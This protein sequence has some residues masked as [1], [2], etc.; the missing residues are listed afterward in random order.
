MQL[1]IEAQGSQKNYLATTA[2]GGDYYQVWKE[3][4][5]PSWSIYCKKY[6]IGLIVFDQNIVDEDDSSYKSGAW[7]KLLIGS[8]LLKE[9]LEASNVCHLDTDI[10]I[11]P[12][13]P[14]IFCEYDSE[15]I[16]V[17]SQ[18]RNMPYD[19]MY[20][21]R[22]I[23]FYRHYFYDERYPLDSSLFIS[24]EGLWKYCGFAFHSDYFCSGVFVFN[25]RKHN[26]LLKS[27]FYDYGSD[28]LGG[29]E[30]VTLN[31]VV[32][33]Y[34]KIQWLDY[35][36]QALWVNEMASKY[37]FLYHYGRNDKLLIQECIESSL[38]TN[39]FL[40][41]AGSWYESNMWKEVKVFDNPNKIKRIDGFTQYLKTPVTGT[42]QGKIRPIR[43]I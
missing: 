25:I 6:G 5:Y 3:Y 30:E 37:P 8:V 38:Y 12:A 2:I 35:R 16:A 40:H 13:S 36:F 18:V 20:V 10:L 15:K 23:A 29:W 19:N 31:H 26:E 4:A 42:P 27:C 43:N 28:P 17:I 14:N 1:L 34:G 9:G 21:R 22:Q 24:L 41:F 33:T 7:Q 39:Y 32:Q 11:S